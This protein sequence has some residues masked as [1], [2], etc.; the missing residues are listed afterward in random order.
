MPPYVVLRA[1]KKINDDEINNISI[2]LTN[3][4]SQIQ[5]NNNS[6]LSIQNASNKSIENINNLNVKIQE[7]R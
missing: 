6:Y 2:K 1:C 7:L 5:V 3:I 4:E